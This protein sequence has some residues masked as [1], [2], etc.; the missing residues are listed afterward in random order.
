MSPGRGRPLRSRRMSLTRFCSCRSRCRL[1]FHMRDR[2]VSDRDCS[3]YRWCRARIGAGRLVRSAMGRLLGRGL[4]WCWFPIGKL[5]R[6]CICY[7]RCRRRLVCGQPWIGKLTGL[8]HVVKAEPEE[9]AY[10]H[11]DSK[12]V[13]QSGLRFTLGGVLLCCLR[14][15]SDLRAADRMREPSPNLQKFAAPTAGTDES[16]ALRCKPRSYLLRQL[17]IT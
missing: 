8:K 17:P 14:T 16:H 3:R 10:E 12:I 6:S 1:S 7:D 13:C 5:R 4:G 11:A 15:R 2:H 9:A